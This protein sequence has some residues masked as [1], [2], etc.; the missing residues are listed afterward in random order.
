MICRRDDDHVA[1]QLI[2]LHQEEGDDPLDLAGLVDVPALLTNGV[3][4]I[5]EQHARRGSGVLEEASEP[6]VGLAEIGSHECIVPHRQ[7][8]YRHGLG[9][10]LSERG[11][12]VARRSRQQNAVT[13]LHALRA[14]EVGTALFLDQL[15]CQLDGRQSEN[16]A[17]ERCPGL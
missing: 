12:P 14:Q 8:R 6:R 5:E 11:L 1:W 4:L 10:R 9:Y 16:Q 15:A 17:F 7:Q 3:E 13:R 2:E